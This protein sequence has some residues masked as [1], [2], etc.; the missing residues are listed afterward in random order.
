MSTKSQG[1]QYARLFEAFFEQP[2]PA[3]DSQSRLPVECSF[4]LVLSAVILGADRWTVF[5]M[6]HKVRM[7]GAV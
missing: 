5:S 2:E 7:N 3:L 6:A 4:L 1:A